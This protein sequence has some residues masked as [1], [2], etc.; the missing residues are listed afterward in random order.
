MGTPEYASIILK[1]LLAVPW[2]CVV[3]ICTQPNKK[4]GRQKAQTPPPILQSL[5]ESYN[6]VIL[7][8]KTFRDTNIIN[9]IHS[10]CPD[11][12]IV[13]AYGRI[14]PKSIL[15]IAPCY[16]LHASLLPK[17][18]GA[19]PIQSALL[20]GD[21]ITGVSLMRMNAQMDCGKW[22]AQSVIEI[23]HQNAVEV[24][25]SLAYAAADLLIHCL[26]RLDS[27]RPLE[28]LHV[29]CSY[30]KKLHKH[31]G[32][33][34][35]DDARG[36][37]RKVLAFEPFPG[38]FLQSGLRLKD[39]EIMQENDMFNSGEILEIT[40]YGVV[41]GCLQGTLL[42]RQVQ[43]PSKQS[44]SATAYINGKRLRVGDSFF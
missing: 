27:L 41:V 33:V 39:V 16:N 15:D 4:K 10:L 22:L 1:A 6:G 23:G 35:F 32:L 30:C 11:V 31:D 18:R 44:M 26:E 19:S 36:I 5:P 21:S 37:V 25:D 12:I 24:F 2:V 43:P 17:Y 9:A 42:I 40:P 38:V 8:P 34:M 13:A 29:D 28:Q 20:H 14:L 7:Q 3:G